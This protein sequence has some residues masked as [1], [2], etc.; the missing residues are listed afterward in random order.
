MKYLET[1][2]S[3]VDGLLHANVFDDFRDAWRKILDDVASDISD[4]ASG[5]TKTAESVDYE[6]GSGFAVKS[7]GKVLFMYQVVPIG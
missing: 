3:P 2:T 4:R 5:E 6:L 1:C 7:D